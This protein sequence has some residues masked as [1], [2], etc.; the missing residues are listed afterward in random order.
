[1]EIEQR[2]NSKLLI[3]NLYKEQLCTFKKL[4]IGKRTEHGTVVTDRL[5]ETTKR[6]LAQLS[7]TYDASL[8]IAARRWRDKNWENNNGI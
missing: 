6:R 4:G 7:A 3:I 1:M 8:T 2:C 5:I